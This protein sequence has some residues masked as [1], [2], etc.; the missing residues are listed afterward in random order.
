MPKYR[1]RFECEVEV[2]ADDEDSAFGVMW[3]VTGTD[4]EYYIKED[5]YA[6]EQIECDECCECEEE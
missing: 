3:D 2:C 1:I 5:T 4:I 6:I